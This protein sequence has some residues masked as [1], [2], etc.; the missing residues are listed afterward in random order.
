[1]LNLGKP[2]IAVLTCGRPLIDPW[3]FE[4]AG[5]VVAA[6]FPG[7][8]AG[9]ALG[10][11]LTGKCNPSGHLPV[12]WPRDT[13]QLPLFYAQRP[14]GRP[15]DPANRNTSQYLDMPVEPQF[16]FGHGLSYTR[17]AYSNLRATPETVR[18]GDPVRV[19]IDIANEGAAAGEATALL[20]VRAPRSAIARPLLELRSMGK[21]MLE[22]G[23]NGTVQFE[24]STEDLQFLDASLAPQLE[25]GELE[26][27]AGPSADRGA[28]LTATLKILP[29][30]AK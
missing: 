25:Y 21:L 26:L 28:L 24:L 23:A 22:P 5:A 4:K 30:D 27:L 12:S 9:A 6:W 8:Q 19:E 14:T 7:S 15:A 13:G 2:V 10:D 11:V 16:P 17:F 3:L 1:M 29:A 20:F 18:P